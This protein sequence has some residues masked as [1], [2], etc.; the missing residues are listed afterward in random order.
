MNQKLINGHGYFRKSKAYGLVCGIALF[1]ALAIGSTASADEVKVETVPTV[2]VNP[3]PATNLETVQ[4]A[5]SVESLKTQAETGQ[6]TGELTSPVVSTELEKTVDSAKKAGVTVTEKIK[7]VV[8]DSLDKAQVDLEKQAEAL[9]AAMAKQEANTAS[10]KKAIDENAEID[11]KNKAEAERTASENKAGQAAVDARNKA[12]QEAVDAR[13]KEEKERVNVENTRLKSEYEAELT[14]IADVEKHNAEVRKRN[15]EAVAKAEAENARRKA[16]YEAK[17]VELEVNTKKEGWLKEL[18]N[19]SLFYTSEP[20]ATVTASSNLKF[21]NEAGVAELTKLL[22]LKTAKFNV[23][24]ISLV[25]ETSNVLSDSKYHSSSVPDKPYYTMGNGKAVYLTTFNANATVTLTQTGLTNSTFNGRKLTKVEVDIS[26][27][28]A[29]SLNLG[30]DTIYL[31]YTNDFSAG[32]DIGGYRKDGTSDYKF[33]VNV[34]PRFYDENGE[35]ID[36]SLSGNQALLGFSSLNYHTN[37]TEGISASGGAR[38]VEINGSSITNHDGIYRADKENTFNVYGEANI[39]DEKNPNFWRLGAGVVLDGK[40]PEIGIVVATPNVYGEKQEGSFLNSI[41]FTLTSKLHAQGTVIPP[42]YEI[43]T[44]EKEKEVPTKPVE[45]AYLTPKVE[46]FNPETFSPA[47]PK[48][49]PHVEVPSKEHYSAN[50]HLVLVKQLPANIKTVVNEDGVDV[51]GKLVPKGST[52]IWVLTN[53]PLIAGRE[54]VTSY[55]ML[56]P[57]PAGFELDKE[58]TAAKNTAWTVSYD[59]T[60]KAQLVATKAT[61]DLLN[62]NRNQDVTVPVAYFVGRPVNDGGTYKNAFT[63]TV[64]T[65]KG[66]YKVVSNIPVIYTPGI[67]PK[68]PRPNDP[69]PYDN[70]IQP[71]KDVVDG[72]G[73]SIN[74]QSVLPNTVLNY[75]AEQDFDQYKGIEASKNAIAK[76]FLYVDDYL[77]EALDGKSL[78]VN[79][80]KSANGDDVRELLDMYHVLSKEAL[81]EKLQAIIKESGI[82]PV[83]EFY[84]WVAKD[85]EAFYKAYVQKGLDISY[86]LSFKIKQGFVGTVTNQAYQVDF[87]NGYYGNIVTNEVPPSEQ[88]VPP[89]EEPPKPAT[90]VKAELPKTGSAASYGLSIAGLVTLFASLFGWKKRQED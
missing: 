16:A 59:K 35:L 10:I 37:H 38:V 8:H 26:V 49:L 66:E 6:K 81:D 30:N 7:P 60:G 86:N 90:P 57:L 67:D 24:E 73:N 64:G 71:K 85:P 70:L 87:G 80:I 17:K 12:G 84:L 76:G 63:T 44:P 61:L 77:D 5:P 52:Q 41:W 53:S 31:G 62:T 75:V 27:D 29:A 42:K 48:V 45:P 33:K 47:T 28:K 65:P 22:S 51:N 19:Q 1:S 58:A 2:A 78:V 82:S 56:D 9:K 23:S 34:A 72:K 50:I 4:E 43:V 89:T 83:G 79:S 21:V 20:N 54:V 74:G 25:K 14:K 40:N 13:N 3:N 88:P 15:A 69:T 18:V 32:F 39:D 11:R 46:T 36:H 55:T 68:T